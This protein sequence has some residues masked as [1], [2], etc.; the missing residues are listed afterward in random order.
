MTGFGFLHLVTPA[1]PAGSRERVSQK[2]RV[3]T[4]GLTPLAGEA[5]PCSQECIIPTRRVYS[6]GIGSSKTPAA[7]N[8]R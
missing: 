7:L 5:E 3:L 6:G 1:A 4:P 8:S 2:R